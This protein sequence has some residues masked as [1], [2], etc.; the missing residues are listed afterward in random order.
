[1]CN[2][3]AKWIWYAN[4]FELLAYHNMIKKRRQRKDLLY[5][6]WIMDRPEYQ[7]IFFGTYDV[8]EKTTFKIYHNGKITVNVNGNPWYVENPDSNIT[9]EKG[10]GTIR[11][12]CMA[13]TG[14][15]C[16]FID[17]KYVKTNES[18][19]AYCIDNKEKPA[20]TN[21]MFTTKEYGPMDYKLPT[22][23][24]RSVSVKEINGGKL[25]DFGKELLAIPVIKANKR[26]TINLFYGESDLEAVDYENSE[27]CEDLKVSA[28]KLTI[29]SES[30][31]LRYVFIKNPQHV[32]DFY[33]LEEYY[34]HEFEPYF[35]SNDERLN[36]IYSTAK[37]TLEVTS[38]EFFIDGPK[39]DRWTWAGDV[40]QSMWFDLCTFFDKEIIKRSLIALIGKQE[41]RSNITGILDYNFY[42]VISVY[43][44]YR[45]TGD[46]DFVK[47]I[48]PRLESLMRFIFTKPKVDG[49]IKAKNEWIFIDW[50]EIPNFSKINN[51]NTISLIQILYYKSLEIMIE[52]EKVLGLTPN[53]VYT[54]AIYGLKEKINEVFYDKEK[55]FF[56][57]DSAHTLKTKYGNI[58][59]ILLDFANKE[60]K[61]SIVKAFE[62]DEFT[63]INTPFMKFYEL[64]ACAEIGNIEYVIDYMNYYWGGMIDEGATTFWEKY[65]P[66]QKGADKYAMY[67]RKYGKSLCHSWGAGPLYLISKYIVGLRPFDDGFN[68]YALKPYICD[69]KYDSKFP[70]K[71]SEIS[72]SCDGR[73]LKVFCPNM[74]GVLVSNRKLDCKDLVYS[75]EK[76]GYLLTAGKEYKIKITEDESVE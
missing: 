68:E 4:D 17:S 40:L 24:L 15:P 45:Y 55:G 8:P 47:L 37:Y 74:N 57:H 69:I 41:I 65:E 30:R 19:I 23:E 43:D 48:F 36:S 44:Y 10:K 26:T 27:V 59:A 16:I 66:S 5:P 28:N 51:E 35:V 52:F 63:N 72:V 1:M 25:Y 29:G 54:Q 58:F 21:P 18:W 62:S 76:G 49:L 12:Y 75:S 3:S 34:P 70:V 39:R 14:M 13:E 42:Y 31:G 73:E 7:V 67:G 2:L 71:D 32:E 33:V 6:T 56:Y 20:S 9:L 64:C 22:R 53:P 50:T 60:Q 11:I 46:I 61:E 38:R